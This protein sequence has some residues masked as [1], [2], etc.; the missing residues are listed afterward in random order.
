MMLHYHGDQLALELGEAAK[1]YIKL[2]MEV[3]CEY[4]FVPFFD[5]SKNKRRFVKFTWLNDQWV[6]VDLVEASIL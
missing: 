3:N 4:V 2:Y 1:E 6:F 5:L